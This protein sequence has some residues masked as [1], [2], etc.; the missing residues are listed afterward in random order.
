MKK[1]FILILFLIITYL[2]LTYAQ[3]W[4]EC[5]NGLYGGFIK[6]FAVNGS[7]IFA[8]TDGGGIFYSTDNC[9]NWLKAN[10]G[11]TNL[12]ITSLVIKDNMIFAGTRGSGVFRSSNFGNNWTQINNGLSGNHVTS[13]TFNDTYIFAGTSDSGVYRS[14]DNGDLWEEVN[15]GLKN[16][17]IT[18]LATMGINI[19]AGTEGIYYDGGV[20]YFS[21]DNGQ[22]WTQTDTVFGNISIFALEVCDSIIFASAGRLFYSTD[23]GINWIETYL[24]GHEFKGIKIINNEI[25]VGGD[26]GV[27]HS[28]DMGLNWERIGLFTKN[29][30]IFG[31][32]ASKITAIN[33]LNTNLIVGTEGNGV[34]LCKNNGKIWNEVNEGLDS[35]GVS[36]LLVRK[37]DILAATGNGVYRSTNNSNLWTNIGLKKIGIGCLADRGTYIF[38]GSDSGK[39]FVSSNNGIDWTKTITYPNYNVSDLAVMGNY[40]YAVEGGDLFQSIN[41]GAIWTQNNNV[42]P[43]QWGRVSS[44]AVKGNKLY[45]GTNQGL[46]LSTDY[47]NSWIKISKGW[48]KDNVETIALRNT[49][50]YAGTYD[51]YIYYSSDEG[52]NWK[53]IKQGGNYDEYNNR[54]HNLKVNGNS[55]IEGTNKG[56][57][58]STDMGRNWSNIGPNKTFIN[59]LATSGT[60]LFAGINKG[61]L[62]NVNNGITWTEV[63]KGLTN[64]RVYSFAESGSNIIAG[65][66]GRGVFLSTNN[67]ANWTLMN[68]GIADLNINCLAADNENILAG[69]S[70]DSLYL[71]SFKDKYWY[72]INKQH[73]IIG[74]NCITKSDSLLFVGSS[75][76]GIYLSSNKGETWKE[77]NNGLPLNNAAY[78][79]MYLLVVSDSIIFAGT[80]WGLYYSTNYGIE[81]IKNNGVQNSVYSLVIDGNN[82]IAGSYNRLFI[83]SN[84]GVNFN[85]I[86]DN[87]KDIGFGS[88]A[89]YGTNIIGCC[90]KE[91]VILSTD[92]GQTWSE[93]NNELPNNKNVYLKLKDK[94]LFAGTDGCGVYKI[95]VSYLDVDD[96]INNES[97][98]NLYPNPTLDKI[99]ISLAS[100]D[101]NNV[102]IKIINQL[103]M[104]LYENNFMNNII[105]NSIT[106]DT[107]K[108]PSGIYYC[109]IRTNQYTETKNFAIIR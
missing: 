8:G 61:V 41:N 46:L 59:C 25:Y 55:I 81:W 74:L 107:R 17:R 18:C 76:K 69:T 73:Q 28:A 15:T 23:N 10:N 39:V 51:N 32:Y 4:E 16:I 90:S 70:Y 54:S 38:A 45:A 95:D 99:N 44:L 37:N 49:E 20:V 80:S 62:L 57:L 102:S 63:N 12:Y 94:R 96:E 34:F 3:K 47:G 87:L 31:L 9:Q 36:D 68:D 83:S 29:W 71:Y 88:L 6:A 104:V 106:I 64:T 43:D 14:S 30:E 66:N 85:E 21:P 108:Y 82:L 105:K 98:I 92:F 53:E 101:E 52:G 50:I 109:V 56:V 75:Y 77:A 79:Y 2:N 60:N 93:Y 22:N 1:N 86:N 35:C 11:L 91:G 89:V 58:V 24:S 5:N 40:I 65:A 72:Q 33:I 78:P 19:F 27:F 100:S 13:L 97:L 7:L 48:T 103:G 84:N 42:F 26:F 67:G